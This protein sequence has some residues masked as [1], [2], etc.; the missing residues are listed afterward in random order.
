MLRSLRKTLAAAGARRYLSSAIPRWL[1]GAPGF[2]AGL[3]LGAVQLDLL[4]KMND[5][6]PLR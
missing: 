2:G 3:A 6:L 1:R 5:H 4:G